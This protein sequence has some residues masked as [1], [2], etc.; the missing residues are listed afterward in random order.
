MSGEAFL[1]ELYTEEIPSF[2]Q[3]RAI[4]DWREKLL[5]QLKD[6]LL[7]FS[8]FETGGTSRRIYALIHDLKPN[9]VSERKKIKGPP[10]EMCQKDGPGGKT[11]T[12][13]LAGF[14]K[15]AGIAENEVT[16]ELWDSKMYATAEI[17]TGGKTIHEVLPGIFENLVKTQSFTRSMRWGSSSLTYARPIIHYFAMYGSNVLKFNSGIWDMMKLADQPA[18]HFILGPEKVDFNNASQYAK[19][20]EGAGILV[21]PQSRLEK[22]KTMLKESSGKDSVIINEKLLDE[23][24][25]LVEKPVVIRGS[26]PHEFLQMPEIVILSEME[27]HQKYFG[28]RA[29]NSQALSNEFLI[30]ANADAND[31][32]ALDNIRKGNEKVLRARLADGSYFFNE[33]RKKKLF[34]RVDD[35]KRMVFHEGMGDG[36]KTIF[37]KKERIKKIAGIFADYVYPQINR[38]KMLRACDL[39]KADLTTHLVYEFDHLQG[40][41]GSIYAEMDGEDNEISSAI[42]EHY[43]PRNE[44]DGQPQ[45]KMGL[46]LSFADKFDNIISGHILGK[47]PTSSQDPLGLRRQTLYIIE[48]L[49]QNKISASLNKIF[50]DLITEVY[51]ISDDKK[52]DSLTFELVK[53]L[54]GRMATIFEKKDLDRK[55]INAGLETDNDIILELFF[56]LDILREFKDDERFLKVVDGFKRMNNIVKDFRLKNSDNIPHV[57]KNLLELDEEKKLYEI[58]DK[59]N[60]MM[61][62]HLSGKK[63]EEYIEIFNYLASVKPDVDH[64]FDNVMVMHKKR[65]IMLN[66]LAILNSAVVSIKKLINLEMLY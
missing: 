50:L 28:L 4:A 64:F 20:M 24:S 63:R 46:L 19:A 35:L 57:D 53:F 65:E 14:A 31:A 48:M 37:D 62:L 39:I 59:L 22:I 5:K 40:E 2:Y 29:G 42:K 61:H 43:L 23:V 3:I 32:G 18:G 47:Q 66:R 60:E 17:N 33:D 54:K 21:N 49:I 36:M 8:T 13:A 12:A 11:M 41:I 51:K 1:F 52:R 34:E 45:S 16:F 55:L 58:I 38:E 30:V 44:N 15:K 10:Q 25:F 9:Q 6:N 56:T 7:E 27:E 26:F